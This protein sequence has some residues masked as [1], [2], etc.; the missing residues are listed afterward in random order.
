MTSGCFR[1][2]ASGSSWR[3]SRP[4][5]ARSWRARVTAGA[6]SARPTARPRSRRRS[7][8]RCQL[9]DSVWPRAGGPRAGACRAELA[10]GTGYTRCRARGSCRRRRCTPGRRSSS[11]PTTGGRSAS[12]STRARIVRVGRRP[13]RRRPRCRSSVAGIVGLGDREARRG[14]VD[15]SIVSA[16]SVVSVVSRGAAVS[17][18]STGAA[19][20]SVSSGSVAC[21]AVESR[22]RAW[23]PP[24]RRR[25]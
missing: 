3:S 21:G 17:V 20:S 15:G 9:N 7:R 19:V 1:L 22:R 5:A 13:R 6:G 2:S 18:V 23:C 11:Q 16:V 25:T 12:W 10:P 14:G 4:Y 24:R 8:R